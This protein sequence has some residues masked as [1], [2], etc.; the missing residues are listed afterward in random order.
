MNLHI[1]VVQ[2]VMRQ[3]G[4]AD[5]MF[6]V[7][8]GA[9]ACR[10]SN[11]QARDCIRNMSRNLAKMIAEEAT[12]DDGGTCHCHLACVETG[13]KVTYSAARW[14]SGT[15]KLLDCENNDDVCM[16]KYAFLC[17]VGSLYNDF[18]IKRTPSSL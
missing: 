3:C 5:P 4:C 10:V 14:P 9:T 13:F 1:F 7:P 11:A 15:A 17:G 6:P 18:Y 8:S 2:A 12:A 16:E